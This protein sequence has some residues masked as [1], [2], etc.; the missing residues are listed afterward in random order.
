MDNGELSYMLD[1]N[2]KRCC[3]FQQIYSFSIKKHLD[4]IIPD[5]LSVQ[6]VA[7][8]FKVTTRT[9]IR[10]EKSGKL[11]PRRTPSG[12]K[13]YHVNDLKG[14]AVE[15]SKKNKHYRP[16]NTDVAH[17]YNVSERTIQNWK[18]RRLIDDENNREDL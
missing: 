8:R 13:Y 1:Q 10:W 7:E 17:D 18:K 9:I 12:R 5:T 2:K 16:T 6:E 11:T 14:L 4:F 15:D 3:T